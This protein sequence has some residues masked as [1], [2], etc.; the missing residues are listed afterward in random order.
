M[1]GAKLFCWDNDRLLVG[2]VY[3]SPNGNIQNDTKLNENLK[4][5]TDSRSHILVMR[6]FNHPEI[7]WKNSLSPP[8]GSHKAT[9][10]MEAVRDAFLHQHVTSPTHV[11]GTQTPNILDLIFSNE[12][13]MVQDVTHLAPLGKSHHQFLNFSF[14]A[15]AP[16][17]T[18][19]AEN[20]LQIYKGDFEKM[21]T[22][23]G[24]IDWEDRL[25][26][27]SACE[28]WESFEEVMSKS[29]KEAIPLRKFGTSHTKARPKWMNRV[30]VK[31][32][33]EKRQ[34]YQRYMK[35][36]SVTDYNT[37]ARLRNHVKTTCRTA[38]RD[39]TKSL[40]QEVKHN[41]KAFYSYVRS[42]T[43]TKQ[44]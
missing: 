24:H 3:R 11:R 36:R 27:L 17:T 44:G 30:A 33:Q 16:P 14:H 6:D 20:K 22:T 25:G 18:K 41:P 42:R 32:I 26:E 9:R 37:Y 28:A 38:M 15:Y 40:A 2:A 1:S 13:E 43:K 8:E 12:S 4:A 29:V 10:F 21:Q 5:I 19:V 31:K 7:D 23:L 34:A 35:S 39:F